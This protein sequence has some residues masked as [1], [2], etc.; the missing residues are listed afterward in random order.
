MVAFGL[1]IAY[2]SAGAN[3][4]VLLVVAALSA[5]IGYFL[6]KKMEVEAGRKERDK[7]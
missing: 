7:I 6:G 3:Y 4:P 5:V 1:L 2:F